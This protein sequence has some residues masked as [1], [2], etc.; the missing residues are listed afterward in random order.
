MRNREHVLAV[1]VCIAIFSPVSAATRQVSP[2]E[3]VAA[4]REIERTYYS[5]QIGATVPFEQA[6]PRGLIEQKAARPLRL[7]AALEAFWKTPITA[8]MLRR[9][10]E[11]IAQ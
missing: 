6:L 4:Q 5:Q 2:G 3:R 10:A 1:A 9:E 11:R 7:S 8:E